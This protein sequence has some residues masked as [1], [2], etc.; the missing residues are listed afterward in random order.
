LVSATSG[1]AM[2]EMKEYLNMWNWESE[3][4]GES[5]VA[6]FHKRRSSWWRSVSR[7]P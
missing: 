1:L 7:P 2:K 3:C 4:W 6:N 5:N